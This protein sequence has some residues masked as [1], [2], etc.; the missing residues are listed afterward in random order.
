MIIEMNADMA[1]VTSNVE[2]IT[3]KVNGKRNKFINMPVSLIDGK[4]KTI[5]KDLKIMK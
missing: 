4:I 2:E 1:E 3:S 5:G